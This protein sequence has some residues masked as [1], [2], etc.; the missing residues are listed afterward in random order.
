LDGKSILAFVHS[1]ALARIFRFS[2][3]GAEASTQLLTVTGTVWFLEAGPGDGFYANMV[4]RPVDVVRFAP[5]GTRLERLA[6]FPQVPDITTMTVLPDGRAVLPVRA[7][8]Q[9]R[10]MTVQKGKDPAPLV[11]TTE[12]TA[13]PVTACGSREVAFMIGPEPHETI[14]F[15]EPTSGRMV[16]TIAPGKGPVD[17]IS[18]S[19]DGKTIYFAARGVVWSTLSSGP[20]A[21]SGARKIRAGDGVVADPS[22]HRLI[23]QVQE[24]LQLHRFSVPL[25]GAPEREIPA[26]S[27]F[28]V[29]PL[30]LSSHALQ[31]DGRLL[32]SLLP[33]DSW[34]NPPGVIDTVS[35]RITRIPTDNLSDYQ[36]I[37]WTPDGQVMALK[38]GLR[39]TLWKF[40][41]VPR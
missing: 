39:A 9:V 15:A 12:E 16:R 31:A 14:A 26:D 22:G 32:T 20:S 1:G 2:V 40:Q 29:A 34:F 4:D 6:T 25:G 10:L 17:S 21:G 33:H 11:N 23:I 28:P 37:G 7:S 18:C 38:I 41:P 36:S 19:P 27:S 3:S 5:D 30:P 8:S 35:G 24:S 13:A